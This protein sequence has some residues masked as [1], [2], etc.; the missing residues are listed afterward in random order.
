MLELVPGFGTTLEQV[1]GDQRRMLPQA[2]TPPYLLVR[3]LPGSHCRN[4]IKW[5]NKNNNKYRDK[6]EGSGEMVLINIVL[7]E[8]AGCER[9]WCK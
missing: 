4:T 3:F 1:G 7:L 6:I 9:C 2:M 5:N 8:V